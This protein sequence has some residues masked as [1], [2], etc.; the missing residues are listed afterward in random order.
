MTSNF[1]LLRAVRQFVYIAG[2]TSPIKL[3]TGSGRNQ[4]QTLCS[5]PPLLP[6]LQ[7]G[8]PRIYCHMHSIWTRI[9]P[10]LAIFSAAVTLSVSKP[11]V[12]S[13][14]EDVL[15]DW[16]PDSGRIPLLFAP[17]CSA[18]SRNVGSHIMWMRD[19]ITRMFTK[20]LCAISM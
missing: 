7:P 13:L 6:S 11:T 17:I 8:P 20:P 1:T 19:F 9:R 12:G 18:I 16:S 15:F 2:Q 4:L 5:G 3:A 14:S 10:R